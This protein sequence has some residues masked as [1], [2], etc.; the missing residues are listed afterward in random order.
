MKGLADFELLIP[1]FEFSDRIQEAHM[2][3]IHILIEEMER[4]LFGKTDV[5]EKE[6][7]S[8]QERMSFRSLR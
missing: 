5:L 4:I 3:L 2:T 6:A 8:R 1:G 7:V